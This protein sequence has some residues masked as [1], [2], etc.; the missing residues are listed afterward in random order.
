MWYR[1]R[2]SIA[3][4]V[5][6]IGSLFFAT[7]LVA[8]LFVP[9]LSP[10]RR[11]ISRKALSFSLR[12][13][14]AVLSTLGLVRVEFQGSLPEIENGPFIA[15]ANHP[16]LLDALLL[17]SVL[18]DCVC[19]VKEDLRYSGFI[20]FFID[21]LGFISN[22]GTTNLLL[23]GAAALSEG[24]SILFFPEGTRTRA[25]LGRFS[26]GAFTLAIRENAPIIPSVI[27]CD[28]ICYPKGWPWYQFPTSS[29]SF[30]IH[31]YPPL[32]QPSDEKSMEREYSFRLRDEAELFFQD[33]LAKRPSPSE[34]SLPTTLHRPQRVI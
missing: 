16:S 15:I 20:R 13:F 29:F 3:Y 7:W 17:L 34:I 30:K 1:T 25:S 19:I 21:Q 18:D 33:Q 24:S 8:L 32:S 9:C 2:A 4:L 26:R 27:Q 10:K 22:S 11:K 28:P 6:G 5:F 14:R 12:I 23:K 31:F